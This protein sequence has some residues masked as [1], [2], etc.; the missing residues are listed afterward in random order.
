MHNRLA[1]HT[2]LL[3][4][5]IA[6]SAC[7]EDGV[8]PAPRLLDAVQ[9]SPVSAVVLSADLRPGGNGA[10][11]FTNRLE[12]DLWFNPCER[13]V[14]RQRGDEWVSVPTELRLCNAMA[15]VL[16]PG[17]ERV[18]LVDVPTYLEAGRYR[19]VFTMYPGV[20]AEIVH[21]PA[22]SVFEVR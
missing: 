9:E 3:A 17:V 21:R 22:S 7:A 1:R 12:D 6:A 5:A 18:E 8:T 10:V 14:Q 15:Y 4:L 19:F 13:E 2:T 11:A 20:D 16:R